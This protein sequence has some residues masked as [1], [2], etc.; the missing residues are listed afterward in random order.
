NQDLDSNFYFGEG[1]TIFERIR[2]GRILLAK[3]SPIGKLWAVDK[4]NFAPRLGFAWDV[5]GDGKTSMRGGYGMAY[6]RNFGNVTFNVIQ[7]PPNY[8]TVALR[9][10]VDVPP[11]PITLDNFGP[12]GGSGISK[13]FPQTSLR[14]VDPD[15]VNAYAHFWSF[16]L[17]R[18]IWGNTIV[19]AE[20]TAS[21]GRKLY[22]IANINRNGTGSVYAGDPFTLG[23]LNTSGAASINF[24]GSDGRSNYNAMILSID[25]SNLRNRGLRLTARYTY[26]QTRDNLSNT[27]AEGQNGNFGLGYLDPF[28]PD[29]DY[30]NSEF[31]VRHRLTST[32]VW[33]IP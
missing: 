10:G 3:D 19:S 33:N 9:N 16:A 25:S 15:I 4:N 8:A 28:N 22:S 17:Q 14:A 29:L 2:N 32:F 27:F 5:F 6:E 11:L 12:L 24:R 23:R 31:D 30:G 26:S 20:Y 18:Q 1:G 21:A 7:N 13:S